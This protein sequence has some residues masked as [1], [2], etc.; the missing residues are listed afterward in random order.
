MVIA[1]QD[2]SKTVSVVAGALWE[3]P[4]A[5]C[6]YHKD[7]RS[8][9]RSKP[10]SV[11]SYRQFKELSQNS[12]TGVTMVR[13]FFYFFEKVE[14]TEFERNKMEEC[15]AHVDGFIHDSNWIAKNR[16]NPDLGLV[17][18]Y[19]YM[20]PVIDTPRYMIWLREK[21]IAMGVQFV[22]RKIEGTLGENIGILDEMKA[23]LL[24]NCTGLGAG[25]LTDD[26]VYPLRG[27]LIELASIPKSIQGAHCIAHN[28]STPQ[29]NMVYMVPRGSKLLLGGIVQK[30]VWGTD[31]SMEDEVI[32]QIMNRCKTFMPD[33]SHASLNP[34]QNTLVGLR[35]AR[36]QNV[37][38]ERET[39]LPVIHNYGHGGSGYTFSWGCAKD[40]A[41]LI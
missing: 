24:I 12:E 17:D 29:Q 21:L 11:E 7:V 15:R 25:N 34:R 22:S 28:E 18:C 40:A 5:V 14:K 38:L 27:A 1:D 3:W 41:N 36:K 26:L 23:D 39:S 37:R 33:L 10:W 4:P 35:P 2:A 20:A 6:G 16:I 30:D 32:R 13:T 8:L 19:S 9:Q 31:L